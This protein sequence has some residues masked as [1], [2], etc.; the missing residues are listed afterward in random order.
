M[1]VLK[2]QQLIPLQIHHNLSHQLY[3]HLQVCVDI[4]CV[5]VT[6][7]DNENSPIDHCRWVHHSSGRVLPVGI[8]HPLKVDHTIRVMAN[9]GDDSEAEEYEDVLKGSSHKD[10]TLLKHHSNP[11]SSS[12]EDQSSDDNEE[13][14]PSSSADTS[15]SSS[16]SSDEDDGQEIISPP[17]ITHHET[18]KK[19]NK[20]KDLMEP[21][22][23]KSRTITSP[24]KGGPPSQSHSYSR[25][26]KFIT[27]L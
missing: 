20:E 4:L 11:G 19:E 21:S 1:K 15:D 14:N 27:I 7:T 5:C 17:E 22:H 9:A 13:Q 18:Y 12:K 6:Y 8:A 2:P 3:V 26:S 25:S 23:V 10:T 16:S 24:F